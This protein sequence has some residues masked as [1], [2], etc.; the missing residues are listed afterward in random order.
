[1]QFK[2]LVIHIIFSKIDIFPGNLKQYYQVKIRQH[3]VPILKFP[4]QMVELFHS[5]NFTIIEL[6]AILLNLTYLYSQL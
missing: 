5:I 1:M 2:L 6:I 4:N 3:I